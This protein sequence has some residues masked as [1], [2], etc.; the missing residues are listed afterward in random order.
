MREEMAADP[1]YKICARKGNDCS[2]RITWEH[3]FKYAG[4]QVQEKWSIIPLCWHHHLGKGLNKRF[5]EYIALLRATKED[6]EKYPRENWE[7]KK[8]HLQSMLAF[9]V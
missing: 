5:N 4:G 9:F 3:A 8:K 7:Q 2:G 1:Y 6:L